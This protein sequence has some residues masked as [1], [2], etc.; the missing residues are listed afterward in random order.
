MFL[1]G[2]IIQHKNK[3]TRYPDNRFQRQVK[4]YLM[5]CMTYLI[6]MHVEKIIYLKIAY[7]YKTQNST[8]L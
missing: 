4:Y 2:R 7:F 8:R 3:Q 1:V 6:Q 5:A